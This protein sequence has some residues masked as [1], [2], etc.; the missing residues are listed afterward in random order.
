MLRFGPPVFGRRFLLVADPEV[1]RLTLG[2]DLERGYAP[3][4]G[5]PMV[6]GADAVFCTAGDDPLHER[7]RALIARHLDGDMLARHAATMAAGWN[8]G[9][10]TTGRAAARR[11][12][13]CNASTSTA[14][15]MFAVQR[16]AV[17]CWLGGRTPTARR[18][19][20]GAADLQ[21][22]RQPAQRS[23]VQQLVFRA[24]EAAR[25]RFAAQLRRRAVPQPR[26][27]TGRRR[28]EHAVRQL[29]A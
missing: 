17:I 23:A 4:T 24:C 6:F 21:R 8:G 20:G 3:G 2:Q 25:G 13:A 7:R 5:P 29:L 28:H 10:R 1:A 9:G 27:D 16:I 14:A 12:L 11:R 15:L 18:D 26:A 22:H 19:A